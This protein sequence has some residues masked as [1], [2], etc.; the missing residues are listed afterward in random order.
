L[1]LE[2]EELRAAQQDLEDSLT[3]VLDAVEALRRRNE[4]TGPGG[5]SW[6]HMD[7]ERAAE[8]WAWLAGFVDFINSREELS[9]T[10]RIPPCW[11]MHGRAVED[12]TAL[13]AA[14]QDAYF[15]VSGPTSDLISYRDRWLWPTLTR[16]SDRN[17]PMQRCVEKGQHH[18]WNQPTDAQFI[19]GDNTK[20]DRHGELAVHIAQDV[21]DRETE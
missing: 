17:N 13:L 16:L 2:I 1:A 12:L 18:V 6:A 4:R 19:S 14:W 3:D 10:M 5:W 21:T 20:F 11:F 15:A 9:P 7:A 8:V